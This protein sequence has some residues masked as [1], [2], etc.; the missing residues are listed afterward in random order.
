[1]NYYFPHADTRIASCG[2]GENN[3]KHVITKKVTSQRV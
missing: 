3:F 1:M 2:S